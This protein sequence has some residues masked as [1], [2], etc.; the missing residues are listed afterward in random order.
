MANFTVI[1]NTNTIGTTEFSIPKNANYSSGSPMTTLGVVYAYLDVS[2]MLA[3][4]EFRVRIYEKVNGGTQRVV[5]EASLIGAQAQL[6][7]FPVLLLGDGWDHTV[8]KI[9][10]NDRSILGSTRQDTNDVNTLTITAGAVNA[11][12]I[13]TDA[14]DAD[15]IKTDAVTELQSGL[16]TSSA[17]TTAQ[18]DLT[19]LTGRLTSTRAG[20]LDNLDAAVTTR[21]PS[22]T[23]LSTAQWTNGRAALLDH[24]DADVS[25]RAPAS[26]A[27][28]TAQYSSARAGFL[29]NLNVGGLVAAQAEV[30]AIQNNTRV[31]RVVPEQIMIPATST[32]TYRVELLLY[33]EVGNMEVPDSAPTIALVNQVGTDLSARLSST[34]MTSISSGR[35]RVT[36]TS[37]AGDTAEQLVWTF[38]VVEGGATRLYGNN[39]LVVD[40]STGGGPDFTSSDRALLTT[41]AA[42]Y[43]TARAAKIDNLDATVSSRAPASTAV[44]NADYTGARATKIDNL[45]AAVTTRAAASTAVSNAD[46]TPTRSAK[47]DNLD[48]AVT[49]RAPASTAVSSADLTPTRSAKLD[50]LDATT[51]SRAPASTAV[52]SADLTPTRAANLDNV[53]AAVS[54]RASASSLASVASDVTTVGVAVIAVHSDT[55]DI[56]TRLPAAL[57]GSGN[58][59]AGVQSLAG[60]AIDSIV[61][62]FFA[63]VEEAGA[64]S[65]ARTFLERQRIKWSILV[66]KATGLAIQDSGSEA[67]RDGADTKNRATFALA[68][69][70]SRTPGTLD[71]T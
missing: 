32:L 54:S 5:F 1:S 31:V 63:F 64:P 4:D 17:L 61:A 19:T 49:T 20:L 57:D 53:D 2:A 24:L 25:T 8:K 26:T 30:V 52:S 50:N 10:G 21:A 22:S 28:S 56:Q 46:L 23:A 71:G 70:G 27:L 29:D 18:T 9:A 15:A 38:S 55:D 51:S 11:A 35:Y 42:D 7:T 66:G 6:Y 16:A 62:A 68:T 44:S 41:L 39:S 45:D 40:Q 58:I 14:I 43:T 47:L 36:Y 60:A 59:K 48:A 69:D 34:T 65:G 3:G 67:F 33:D 13:A 37:T 12:A